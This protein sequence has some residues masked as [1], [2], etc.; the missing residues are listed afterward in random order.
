MDADRLG[1]IIK[2]AAWLQLIQEPQTLLCERCGEDVVRHIG[3]TLRHV[4]P[5]EVCS[6]ELLSH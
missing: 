6:Y 4:V 3:K 2:G 1:N 5:F